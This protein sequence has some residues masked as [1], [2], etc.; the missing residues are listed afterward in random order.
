MRGRCLLF[1][2]CKY[3]QKLRPAK[4]ARALVLAADGGDVFEVGL[5]LAGGDAQDGL[6]LRGKVEV[7]GVL[8]VVV[9]DFDGVGT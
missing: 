9:A 2:P 3:R 6:F 4:R 8:G 5:A 1:I 7:L